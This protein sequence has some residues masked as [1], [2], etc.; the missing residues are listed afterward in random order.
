[1][2]CKK[3]GAPIL[4]G[5]QFCKGC[6]AAV[7]EQNAQ[8][9]I[10]SNPNTFNNVNQPMNMGQPM[11][12]YNNGTTYQP[13][14]PTQQKN[15]ST[16]YILIGIGAV[17]LIG[18]VIL[19]FILTGKK[20]TVTNPNE[21]LNN[22]GTTVVNNTSTYKVNF[23]NFTFNIPNDYVYT[24]KN[25]MMLLS[26]SSG[27]WAAA[28]GVLDGAS[29]SQLFIN[30][31]SIQKSLISNGYSSSA[32]VEKT[33]KGRSFIT[34]ETSKNNNNVLVAY[35]DAGMNMIFGVEIYTVNNDYDYNV[36]EKVADILNDA[37]YNATS[38][39]ITTTEII[40]FNIVKELAQ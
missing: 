23:S 37:K 26:D 27:T 21:D 32:A 31:N 15:N 7:N 29:Y 40:D 18:I 20:G 24:T 36:L 38:N 6:G 34:V 22:G 17:I 3:C 5:D 28:V 1:M 4:E 11:N 8:N 39:S 13:S 35:S 19:I 30:K 2:N 33:L 10:E 12:N 14:Y 9:N 25:N 16:K